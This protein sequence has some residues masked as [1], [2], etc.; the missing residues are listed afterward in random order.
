MVASL[1]HGRS[2]SSHFLSRLR[3]GLKLI[4][5]SMGYFLSCSLTGLS[6]YFRLYL[7]LITF[8]CRSL[9]APNISCTFLIPLSS[10]LPMKTWQFMSKHLLT[11][12]FSVHSLQTT[13]L[14]VH[15]AFLGR[16]LCS[17]INWLDYLFR[18]STYFRFWL[19]NIMS[20]FPL[21]CSHGKI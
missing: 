16:H 8:P 3:A 19:D 20:P 18:V 17:V 13:N 9:L 11:S 21:D 12:N 1:P 6:V 7:I 14:K 4:L 10:F 15:F 2:F 5:N